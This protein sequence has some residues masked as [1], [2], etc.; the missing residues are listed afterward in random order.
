MNLLTTSGFEDYELID[1]GDGKRFERFGQY[2]L[3]RPDPQI[4]WKPNLDTSEW[5]KADAIFE[6][7]KWN[8][9][10]DIPDKWLMRWKNISLYAKLTPFKHT[11]VFPEQSIHWEFIQDKVKNSNGQPNILNLFAYTGIASLVAAVAGAKVTHLDAS[12]PTIAWARENQ[13]AS[14]LQDKPIRWI[15]D[16][17]IKFTA[18][19]IKRGNKYDAIIMDPPVYG[20][21]P[22]GEIWD[23]NKSLPVLL[24][25]CSKIISD[26]PAFLIINGYAVTTSSETLKNIISSFFPSMT[27]ESGE[28]GIEEKSEKR[29]LS[30]GIFV[31]AFI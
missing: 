18:R 12:K 29:V 25:N 8:K 4:I 10:S 5:S 15:L 17:A 30:T 20:H 16:D 26:T 9:K 19:E 11:G 7:E 2:R 1:S 22:T 13:E 23:F 14:G 6:G 27:V 28:L 24:E 21:G 31:R 3:I